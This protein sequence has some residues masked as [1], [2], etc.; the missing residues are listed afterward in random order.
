[1][2]FVLNG[3]SFHFKGKVRIREYMLRQA[4]HDDFH[5]TLPRAV[6]LSMSKGYR[7]VAEGTL[8]A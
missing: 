8:E 7:R 3:P 5:G 1:M 4:Q 6:T 2:N